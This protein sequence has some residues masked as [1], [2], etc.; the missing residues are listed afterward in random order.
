MAYGIYPAVKGVVE[1]RYGREVEA[2]L[3][4]YKLEEAKGMKAVEV[5]VMKPA[6]LVFK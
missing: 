6:G 3:R 2:E 5:E 1:A 4:R